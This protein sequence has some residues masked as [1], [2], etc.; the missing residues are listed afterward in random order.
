MTLD[1]LLKYQIS[2]AELER[3]GFNRKEESLRLQLKNARRFYM[4]HQGISVEMQN[5][6]YLTAEE[7]AQMVR[8]SQEQRKARNYEWELKG[9][10]P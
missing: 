7:L 6:H 4:D 5:G 1:D 10:G 8:K 9:L 2:N 3:A